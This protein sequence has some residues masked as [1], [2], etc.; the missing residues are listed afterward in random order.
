[1]QSETT[2]VPADLTS[3]CPYCGAVVTIKTGTYLGSCSDRCEHLQAVERIE[4]QIFVVFQ[5]CKRKT[6]FPCSFI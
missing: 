3:K 5:Q 1:M 6:Q 4:S 2:L